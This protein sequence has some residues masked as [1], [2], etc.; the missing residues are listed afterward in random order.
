[1]YK[2]ISSYIFPTKVNPVGW[3]TA[4]RFSPHTL[5]TLNSTLKRLLIL[6]GIEV[7]I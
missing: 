7:G 3:S 5:D 2:A 6:K 4:Q 1:M